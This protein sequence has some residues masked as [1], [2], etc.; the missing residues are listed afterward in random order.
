MLQFPDK[1][2]CRKGFFLVAV[3]ICAGLLQELHSQDLEQIGEEKPVTFSGNLNV[4]TWIYGSNGIE[5]RR[6]PFSWYISGSPTISIY[7]LTLPFSFTIS[8]QQRYFSQPFNRFGV[9]PYYKWVTLHAGYRNMYFSDY[10]LAG[11]VFLGGGVEL[12]PGKFRFAA[13]YGRFRRA[14][15]E[16]TDTSL[17]IPNLPASYKR[18]GYGMKVG[19]GSNSSFVDF[20]FFKAADDSTSLQQRPVSTPVRPMDNLVVGIRSNILIARRVTLNFDISGS[21]LTLDTKTIDDFEIP[22]ELARYQNIVTI[23]QSTVFKTAGHAALQYRGDDFGLQFRVKR[24]DP[25]YQSLGIYY[26]QSD[27]IDYTL[28]PDLR[29][30]KGKLYLKSSFGIRK[31]NLNNIKPAE[32]RRTIGSAAVNFNPTTKFGMSLNYANYGTSQA[33]GLIQLNDSIR[34]SV[35]NTTYGGNVRFTNVN[36]RFVSSFII[37][38]NYNQF[39]DENQYTKEFT[40]SSSVIGNAS[41]NF[42]IVKTGTSFN[43]SYNVSNFSNNFNDVFSHG[44]VAGVSMQFLEKK[45]TTGINLN[46]QNR[47]VGEESDGGIFQASMRFSYRIKKKHTFNLDGFYT[48]NNSGNVSSFTYNE[49]RLS[50]RYGYTF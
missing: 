48:K 12:N 29:L 40:E 21:A 4:G 33:S 37:M 1:C 42:S 3:L 23:N 49:Q 15:E 31:D 50:L 34:M 25:G 47:R 17:N 20:V 38:T 46:Y 44:P 8:E 24:I 2:Y 28:S 16:V 19:F 43:I 45:L 30:F 32:T 36:E 22:D 18:T 6:T 10:T 26:I 35:V 7:N 9:S 11:E 14:V 5:N 39:E 13:M 41:Y 27:L